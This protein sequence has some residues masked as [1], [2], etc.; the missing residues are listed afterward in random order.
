M[1]STPWN[2]SGTEAPGRA[3]PNPSGYAGVV[4]TAVLLLGLMAATPAVAGLF[5]GNDAPGRIPVPA[6]E[7]TASVEDEGGVRTALTR[8]SFDGEI[9]LFGNLGRAQVTV[10]FDDIDSVRFEATDD[11]D[12]KVAIVKNKAGEEIRI[13]VE[14]DRPLFGRTRFGNYRIEVEDIRQIEF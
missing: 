3:V 2:R 9:Y 13:R 1:E 6:R 14:Y 8:V 4:R 11:D 5:G 12:W 10:H 7:F